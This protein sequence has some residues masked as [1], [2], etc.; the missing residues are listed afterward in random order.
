MAEQ[1]PSND[2]RPGTTHESDFGRTDRYDNK[3][4]KG[5]DV[6]HTRE[7]AAREDAGTPDED[8]DHPESD[9]NRDE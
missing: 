1:N 3:D 6:R 9:I 8:P 7:R 4:E 5:F 2:P